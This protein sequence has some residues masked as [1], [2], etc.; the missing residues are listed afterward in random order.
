MLQ[1]RDRLGRPGMRL[2]AHAVQVL[3]ADLE[4]MA[5]HR[6]V[7]ERVAMPP[8]GFLG[9]LAEPDALDA[10]G[11]AEEE[12]AD[13][14]ALQSDRVEDL[15]AAIRLIGRDAH[16]G[17]HLEDA[18]VDRLDVALDDLLVVELLRH[19]LLH[20]DQRLEGE[21]RIDRLRAVAGEAAEVV[22]LA[23]FAG[24]DHHADGGAQSLADQ[25]MMHR[26][27]R[28]QRRDR[29]AVRAGLAVGQDDDV[30][31]VAHR[32]LGVLA[33]ARERVLHA[34]R[35]MLDRVGDVERARVELLLD[36]ADRA[37]LLQI[38]VGEDRLAHFEPLLLGEPLGIEQVGARSDEGHERHH[39]LLAD[40]VDRRVGH[41]REVL[42]E[43]GVEQL[44]L[45][46]ERRD[47]RVGAHRADRFLAGRRHRLHQ[48]LQVF[49]AVAEALLAIEQRQ[50]GRG[51][52]RVQRRQVFQH[53]LRLLQPLR[54]GMLLGELRLDLLVGDDA[55]F[56]QVDQQHLA[57]LQPPL[58]HDLAFRDRQHAGFRRH[59]D[60]LVRGDEPARRAQAV[61][62]ERRADLASIGE[63]D[64]RRAVPR[65]HQR[66]VIFVERAALLIHQRIAGPG[67]RD[68]HH[69]GMR[70]RVAALGQELE[71]IVEAGGVGLA[72]VGDRP[73]LG[74]VVAEQ[75][76]RHR[77]L[78]RRHPVD[79][80]AQRVD[81]A[82]VRHHAIRM[83]QRPARERVGG[84]ALVHQAER[85]LEV[86]LVQVGIVLAE[87][88]GEEHALVD[89]GAARQRHDVVVGKP[90]LAAAIDH[91]GDHLAQDVELALELVLRGDRRP[92]RDEHLHVERLGR[93]HRFA[94]RGIVVRHL[95][96][97]EQDEALPAAPSRRRCRGSP[98]AIPDRAA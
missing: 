84:E 35:A 53:E 65:L 47:R 80:A 64:R 3:A 18:L 33:Q 57:R 43:I 27:G 38:L 1:R 81:L 25:V 17:H 62:V 79:V 9:D 13:E 61:A 24:L 41:L 31:A 66:R 32:L 29:N 54:I 34:A 74:D 90:P 46:G 89:H 19:L 37:D 5:Q 49:L 39:Q 16:L 68:Q 97:A 8:R 70:E 86:L 82:V 95:A 21:I 69:G 20:A 59:D 26:R 71:R 55:A 52:A 6:H 67:F 44:R 2:A 72:L 22:H 63:R 78:P 15:R 42:L 4:R 11:G 93:L 58:L 94:E 45:V 28:E 96:P 77:G 60:A 50:V 12:L 98:S 23:R 92:A 14:I 75:L 91:V 88:V 36:M 83:R 10:R 51:L 76:R 30:V 73:Q 48:E 40:R 87:L 7:A 85:G 56:G